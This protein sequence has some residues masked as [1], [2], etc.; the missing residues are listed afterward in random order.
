MWP[1]L[2]QQ[3]QEGLHGR[4]EASSTYENNSQLN[5]P[6]D[7]KLVASPFSWISRPHVTNSI[8]IV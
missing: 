6:V 2:G 4:L 1:A 5:F 7:P 3:G 8:A